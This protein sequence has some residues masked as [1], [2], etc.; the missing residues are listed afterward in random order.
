MKRG[1]HHDAERIFIRQ[2]QMKKRKWNL[3]W[4]ACEPK[5]YISENEIWLEPHSSVLKGKCLVMSA[6]SL[7]QEKFDTDAKGGTN[8]RDAGSQWTEPM[9]T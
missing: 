2:Y 9:D 4:A 7:L 8:K 3:L 1:S 6:E 5:Q